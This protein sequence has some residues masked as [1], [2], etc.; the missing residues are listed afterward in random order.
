MLL[1]ETAEAVRDMDRYVDFTGEG[2]HPLL[3]GHPNYDNA[4]YEGAAA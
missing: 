3:A 2:E 4:V 1:D